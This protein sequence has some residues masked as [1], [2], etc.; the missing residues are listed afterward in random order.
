[1]D[2]RSESD[3]PAYRRHVTVYSLSYGKHSVQ[4][5]YVDL[6]VCDDGILI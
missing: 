2:A 4:Y 6:E 5:E 1:M 3:I